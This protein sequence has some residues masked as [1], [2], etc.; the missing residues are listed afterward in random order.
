M[1]AKYI[2]LSFYEF[3]WMGAELQW[4]SS[5]LLTAGMEYNDLMGVSI[6]CFYRP[7]TV[8]RDV[9]PLRTNELT[10]NL[11][12]PAFTTTDAFNL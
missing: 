7:M 4:H 2:S 5:D 9:R 3:A 12:L 11:E 1:D 6:A 8:E 10:Q